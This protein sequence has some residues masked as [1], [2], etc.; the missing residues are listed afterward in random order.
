MRQ[1]G[2]SREVLVRRVERDTRKS[3][4]LLYSKVD[5]G[6]VGRRGCFAASL[7][8]RKLARTQLLCFMCVLAAER[9]RL[10]HVSLCSMGWRSL[11]LAVRTHP[12][13]KNSLLRVSETGLLSLST[14]TCMFTCSR[15]TTATKLY[16][17]KHTAHPI[18]PHR[19]PPHG[20]VQLAAFMHVQPRTFWACR[21]PR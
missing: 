16:R 15:S 17:H 14:A 3:I 9:C 18:Q 5:R 13:S 1:T 2:D 7:E 6:D 10:L 12:C 21:D 11:L 4:L 20:Y 19:V 8:A